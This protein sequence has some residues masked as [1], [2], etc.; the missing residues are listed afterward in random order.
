MIRRTAPEPL[1]VLALRPRLRCQA[2]WLSCAVHG[3]GVPGALAGAMDR[4]HRRLAALASIAWAV[5]PDGPTRSAI[6]VLSNTTR[7]LTLFVNVMPLLR[8]DSYYILS[9]LL[10]VANLQDRAFAHTRW[11][12]RELLFRPG[13]PPPERH[14][15][16]L[17]SNS[18]G[19]FLRLL[20]L[21]VLRVLGDRDAGRTT[22]PSRRW[23]SCSPPSKSGSSSPD[24]AGALVS[25][26][27]SGPMHIARPFG[28]RLLADHRGIRS[29][30]S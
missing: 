6:L 8:F 25:D 29:S 13:L 3:R 4:H 17:C 14:A 19:L 27:R 15:P 28:A 21:P 7:I 11:W 18:A 30:H 26:P 23:Q 5:L 12:M 9:D 20:V 22:S 1:T 2:L 16:E 10:D 24:R